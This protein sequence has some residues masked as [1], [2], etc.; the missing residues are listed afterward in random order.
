MAG[1]IYTETALVPICSAQRKNRSRASLG[2]D[3]VVNVNKITRNI[4]HASRP[5][6]QALHHLS[7]SSFLILTFITIHCFLCFTLR[8][9]RSCL[10]IV[11]FCL[12][13]FRFYC[14]EWL[15]L[16]QIIH[17]Q[18]LRKPNAVNLDYLI[19]F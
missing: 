10:A 15:Y 19:I 13:F 18:V 7:P 8:D 17:W 1:V 14:K 11:L 4:F 9:L 5:K 3:Y 6:W 2:V 16:V 12:I